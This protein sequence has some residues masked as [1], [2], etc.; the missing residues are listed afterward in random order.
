MTDRDDALETWWT[1]L[2]TELG[3][4]DPGTHV[5]DVLDLAAVAAHA[6]VRPAAPLTTF[7]VGYAA[8]LA[9]GGADAVETA[10]GRATRL[11]GP[12]GDG[13]DGGGAP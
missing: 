8:G 10:T 11:A 13:T 1:D 2:C 6:V 7:L 12:A 4:D 5:A 3:I 9:G